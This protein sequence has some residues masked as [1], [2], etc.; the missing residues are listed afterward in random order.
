MLPDP[1]HLLSFGL[2]VLCGTLGGLAA[3][4]CGLPLPFL[5]GGLCGGVVSVLAMPRTDLEK[6][7]PSQLRALF[8]GVIGA[9]IGATFTPELLALVPSLPVTLLAMTLF[10][11]VAHACGYLV[12]RRLGGYN[13]PTAFFGAM[14]GG[15][16]E[17]ITLGAEVGGDVRVLTLH[18]LVRVVFV[19]VMMPLVFLVWQGQVVG[20][21][22]ADAGLV[23]AGP[24]LAN[25]A[26]I[27]LVALIGLGL[28][29][30]LHLPAWHLLGP[31][32]LAATVQGTGLAALSGPGWL[33]ALA[34]LMV[35]L[36]LAHQV[37]GT[38]LAVAGRVLFISLSTVSLM[39]VLGSVVALAL[40][41][42]TPLSVEGLILS[43]APGGITE[44]GLIALSL[45]VSPVVVAAHHMYRIGLTVVVASVGRRFFT[46]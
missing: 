3:R 19:A 22:G 23:A 25:A 38:S 43:F 31:M 9:L 30:L 41:R 27:C 35:G 46:G 44:M 1:R 8:I 20:R 24:D 17:A 4:A 45:N 33:L 29:R 14:P 6:A 12:C 2:L 21:A 40:V 15:F 10:V 26:V 5:L 28:G 16:V 7:Y 18:H 13:R 39:L 34:Q 37:A 32:A 42:L 36:G 11:P